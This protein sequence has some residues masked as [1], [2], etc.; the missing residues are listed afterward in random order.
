MNQCPKPVKA[1]VRVRKW[2]EIEELERYEQF[3]RDWHSL[4]TRCRQGAGRCGEE[5]RK[6]ASLLLLRIFYLAP[7]ETEADFY[8]QFEAR[9]ESAG[10]VLAGLFVE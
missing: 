1:K 3:V 2:L 5:A 6:K 7:Y 9:K 8:G 4:L 10:S